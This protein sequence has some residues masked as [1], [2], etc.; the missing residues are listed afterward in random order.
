MTVNNPPVFDQITSSVGPATGD[1]L[2]TSFDTSDYNGLGVGYRVKVVVFPITTFDLY[3]TGTY[4]VYPAPSLTGKTIVGIAACMGNYRGASTVE[5]YLYDPATFN[6]SM[7]A[8]YDG[9]DNTIKFKLISTSATG[10][11]TKN[12]YVIVFYID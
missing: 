11:I 10:S 7:A 2:L 1:T 6:A 3:N 5:Q 9:N 8:W 12:G 4:K